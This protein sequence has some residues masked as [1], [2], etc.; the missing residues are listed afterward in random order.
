MTENTNILVPEKGPDVI[1]NLP[2]VD[3]DNTVEVSWMP[4]PR[5][6]WRGC[7]RNYTLYVQGP[8]EKIAQY[9]TR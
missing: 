8:E 9:G 1:R 7:L 2:L 5:H 4:V 6:Q 3:E